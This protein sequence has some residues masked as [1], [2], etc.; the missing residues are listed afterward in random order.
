MMTTKSEQHD[1]VTIMEQGTISKDVDPNLIVS[2]PKQYLDRCVQDKDQHAIQSFLSRPIPIFQGTWSS[3][4][5]KG[6]VLNNNVFPK[7]LLGSL[8]N[9][10]YKLDGFVSFSATVVYR[11]QVNSV[12]TQAGAL[13]AH[14]VPYSEYMNSHTQWYSSGTTTDLVA[15]TG[16]R[17]VQMNLA[18]ETSMEIRVPL[19][20]PYASFN[21]VTGQGSFGSITLSVYSALSSQAASSCSFTI[22]AWFE[23]VDVRFPTS[24]TLTTN[25]AQVGSEMKKMESTGVISSATGQIGRG[26]AKILP[27]VGLGWLST[28]FN[29]LADGAEFVLKALGFSKPSVEAPNTIMKIAPTRFFLNG[30]GADTSHKLAISASN[31]LTSIPG[32]A[33]TDIDEMR[34]DYI[35]GR[36]CFTR[37]FNWSINDIADTQIFSIPTG[38]LYTQ[39]LSTKIANA[40][41]RTVSLPLCAKV[42]SLYSMWRGD[43]VYTFRVVKT[44]FHSGRLIASFRPYNY[45]DSSRTQ[46]MPAYNYFTEL[47]LSLGTDFTFRV[48]FVSTR[49]FLFTNYDMDNALSSSDVRNS[50]SGTMTI[51]VMN[52]LIAAGTVASTVEVLVE[53]HMENATFVAP[54]KP[55]HLP[56]GIPNV[57]Q[58]GSTPRVV[59]GKNASEITP[60]AINLTEHGMCVGEAALSLRHLLKQFYPLAT[61]TLNSQAATATLPGQSGKAFTLFPWAPVIPQSGSITATTVNNQKPSYANVYTYGTTVFNEIPDMF[62]ILYPNYAFFRG[63]IRYKIVVAKKSASFDSELP[64]KVYMNTW[65]QDSQGPYTPSMQIATP[66]NTN[67]T[68][69]LLGSGP[70]QPVYDVAATTAGSSTYQ[71]GFVEIEL[72]IIYNKDGIVEFEVPFYNSGHSVPTNYGL[73]TPLSMRSIVYPV[74]QVTVYC[75]AFPT[76]TLQVYRGVGDDFEFGALLGAPQHAAWQL[77]NAPT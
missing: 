31:A 48:P 64:I 16:C 63:S 42:A 54:V 76:C 7:D 71:P 17:R 28:P 41:T 8:T 66:A 69:T 53:V 23:D 30:D 57:A 21:L 62:S 65:T 45:A 68:Y 52:P 4:A 47:D 35:A 18:N 11:V 59:K 61:V 25:F 50:A 20:G 19:S 12:P 10:T 37:A 44:Q 70:I 51:S 3:T 40:W 14:Y 13:V 32:W 34:L 27:V 22:L 29:L 60:S 33:G 15:A 58:V 77:M 73:D 72:P 2:L 36:P 43:L 67:G 49:P 55:R 24:A 38:P 56:F 46:L 26:I 39:V 9:N 75:D 1:T 6:T 5:I 74:P